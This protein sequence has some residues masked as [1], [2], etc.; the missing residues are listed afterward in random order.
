VQRR[1]SAVSNNC[2]IHG[3]PFY[4]LVPAVA[5]EKWRQNDSA[6]RDLFSSVLF[7]RCGR[8][9]AGDHFQRSLFRGYKSFY[10]A[11]E[12]EDD[13]GLFDFH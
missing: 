12:Q 3:G 9:I 1:P 5:P 2:D 13:S 11:I 7:S 8:R 10:R 6:A 4:S